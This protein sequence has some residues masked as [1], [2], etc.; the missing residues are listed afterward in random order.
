MY[1]ILRF[2]CWKKW[3]MEKIRTQAKLLEVLSA[4][5]AQTN[6]KDKV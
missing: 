6:N 1:A 5:G 4:K 3:K 2:C